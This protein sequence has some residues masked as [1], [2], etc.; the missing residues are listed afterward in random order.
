MKTELI[1]QMKSS[2][3]ALAQTVPDV[4]GVEFWFARDLQDPLGYARWENF[5][6]AIQRAIESCETTGYKVADHFRGVTK[7]ITHGKGGQREIEDF[8]LTRYACYLIAQNGDPRKEPI[9]FAQSYF[10]VQTR[11]Q[12]LIE[13]RMR[14][15]G[16]L[17]ARDKLRASEKAL[18]NNIFERGVDD[19]GFGRI[20]SKGDAALFGGHTTQAMKDKFGITRT[21]PLADFLPTLTIA[22]KNLATEMTNH[23]V[24]QTDLQGEPSITREHVQNNT[25]VRQMLGQ[26]GIKPEALPPEEDIKKL[27]RRVKTEEKKLEQKS[28]RLPLPKKDK[29]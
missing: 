9:A 28:G 23:N 17:E 27:E 4:E 7:L 21:R 22:A 12:E 14:L 13:E 19:A 29:P 8:M 26:R 3:D 20:R 1:Q 6:T 2:F 15:M 16:R 24:Q 18:S 5:L 11:K 25:S 10:A